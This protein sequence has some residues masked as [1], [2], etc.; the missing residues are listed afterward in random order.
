MKRS[1]LYLLV[2]LALLCV[3]TG[4]QVEAKNTNKGDDKC[5]IDED[6]DEEKYE[7]CCFDLS[8]PSNWTN[9]QK[10]WRKTCC[11]N[12]S[13]SP[14]IEPPTNLTE[15]QLDQVILCWPSNTLLDM[16]QLDKGISILAP[17]FLDVLVCEGIAYPTM[18]KLPSCQFYTTTTEGTRK[19]HQI[20]GSAIRRV[21]LFILLTQLAYPM[22][23]LFINWI[24]A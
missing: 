10:S 14:I 6:C 13:G 20:S 19:L 8:S 7:M 5:K 21:S 15:R 11:S 24:P 16:F 17:I 22:L 4:I 9:D 18:V 1:I 12:P 3:F 2:I 23:W